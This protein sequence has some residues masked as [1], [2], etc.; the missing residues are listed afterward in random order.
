MLYHSLLRFLFMFFRISKG[1]VIISAIGSMGN[2][3]SGNKGEFLFCYR[4]KGIISIVIVASLW[5]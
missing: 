3:Y 5:L 2:K 1:V 4:F